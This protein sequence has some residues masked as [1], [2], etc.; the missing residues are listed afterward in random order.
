MQAGKLET[1]Q[2]LESFQM[3]QNPFFSEIISWQSVSLD[4]RKVHALTDIPPWK[5]KKELQSFMEILN[6][7]S[8]FSSVTAEVCQLLWNWHQW[9]LNGHGPECTRTYITEQRRS[10]R[11]MHAWNFMMYLDSWTWNVMHQ[12]LGLEP[13]YFCKGWHELWAW[14]STKQ[15]ITVPN[16]FYQ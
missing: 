7:L 16:C 10:S 9:R 15:C 14:W 3:Y 5:S 6:F 13:D 11:R 12:V 1:Y 8:R 4:S 2:R